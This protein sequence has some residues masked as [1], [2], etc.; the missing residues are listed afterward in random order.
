ML[1]SQQST[2]KKR[3]ASSSSSS[4]HSRCFST[5]SN[6]S[7]REPFSNI[8]TAF[9]NNA[10]S[11]AMIAP[12]SSGYRSVLN[13]YSTLNN[14]TLRPEE[15]SQATRLN[16]PPNDYVSP[17]GNGYSPT[18]DVEQQPASLT[19]VPETLL[20]RQFSRT[21]LLAE[22]YHDGDNVESQRT[23]HNREEPPQRNLE[24][25][26]NDGTLPPEW[27]DISPDVMIRCLRAIPSR[28]LVDIGMKDFYKSYPSWSKMTADQRN[29]AIAWF[30][31]LPD[32]MQDDAVTA[33]I[34]AQEKQVQEDNASKVI[35]TKDD[36]ARLLHLFKEPA[37]QRHWTN[38]YAVLS[39]VEL[40]AR[41]AAEEYSED[42]NPLEHLAG[43]FN[44]YDEFCPQNVMV[45]YVAGNGGMPVKKT[46]YAPSSSEWSYLASFTHELDPCNVS[47]RN[48]I[49]GPDWVKSTWSDIRK[50]LHQMFT[51]YH[52]SGQHDPDMDEWMSEKE[53]RRWARAAGWKAPGTNNVVR[54]Q[55][56]MIYSIAVLD[57]CDFESIG[58]KM[59]KGTG[60]DSSVNDGAVVQKH[61][62]KK[63]KKKGSESSNGADTAYIA[64]A[65]SDGNAREAKMSALRLLF[66]F[67]SEEDKAK[68]REELC[69]IAYGRCVSRDEPQQVDLTAA[70]DD[71][72]SSDSD[73]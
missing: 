35:T 59:P 19:T 24:D 67:G 29:R 16:T 66:E 41:K 73:L 65:I 5:S 18:D 71:S 56:A 3:K 45:Q 39:R 22:H 8:T 12:G 72:S 37:A 33:A 30:R 27:E 2:Q 40:D 60:V 1:N 48:I 28:A 49:R 10:T 25:S 32:E 7:N 11:N 64:L 4:S 31:Q 62:R 55:Q 47:R 52:R 70:S 57:L 50:Y 36:V 38:L 46:P 58:R 20:P 13:T 51:Q 26:G 42:A 23:V 69:S 53:N 34:E 61:K 14:G 43:M 17:L 15:D 9:T 68:A 21:S 6:T 54:H 63:R 44:N